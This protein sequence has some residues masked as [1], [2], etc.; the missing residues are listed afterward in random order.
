MAR[1][2]NAF[3]D[4]PRTVVSYSPRL[5]AA[6]AF[7]VCISMLEHHIQLQSA[8]GEMWYMQRHEEARC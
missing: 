1:I 7:C 8:Y 4:L 2:G 3:R 5:G 6:V